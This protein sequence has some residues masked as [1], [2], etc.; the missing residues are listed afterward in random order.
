MVIN[1]RSDAKTVLID[2]RYVILNSLCCSSRS[3]VHVGIGISLSVP[4]G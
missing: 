4:P 3:N 2:V 1:P